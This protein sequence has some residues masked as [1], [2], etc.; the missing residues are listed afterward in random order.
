MSISVFRAELY[1]ALQVIEGEYKIPLLA[2]NVSEQIVCLCVLL[3][4]A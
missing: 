4:S 2:Q 1:R 3:I